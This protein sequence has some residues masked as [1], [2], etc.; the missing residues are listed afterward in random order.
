[1]SNPFV[2]FSCQLTLVMIFL[3]LSR[4]LFAAALSEMDKSVRSIVSG[5]ISYSRWPQAISQPTL[6]I[7][8]SSRYINALSYQDGTRLSYHAIIVHSLQDAS[9]AQCDSVYFGQETPEQQVT[10]INM[11][12]ARPMLL[13]SEQNAECRIGSAFCLLFNTDKVTFS[14]NL[15]SLAR[16]GV[17]VNPD[18]LM[19][20]RKK[21]YE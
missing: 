20:A 7:F 11:S 12:R 6:C 2:K 3:S 18:V 10:L 8:H 15:D 5:V 9:N 1:M 13:I 14:V 21:T 19:L 17:R 4:P 16:S